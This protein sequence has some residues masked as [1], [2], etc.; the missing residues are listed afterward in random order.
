MSE[1]DELAQPSALPDIARDG[2][3]ALRDCLNRS[4][5]GGR[6]RFSGVGSPDAS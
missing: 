4:A 1:W 3:L 2:L 6:A 5:T